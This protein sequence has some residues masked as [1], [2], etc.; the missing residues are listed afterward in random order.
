MEYKFTDKIWLYTG[1]GAWHFITLP[2]GI[3]DEIKQNFGQE[4]K[5]WGSIRVTVSIDSYRWQTSIFPDKKSG[6]YI[7]PVKV[8][9]RKVAGLTDGSKAGVLLTIQT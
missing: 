6:A 5:G 2:K 1:N 3:S 7:L 8:E 4:R 9:A